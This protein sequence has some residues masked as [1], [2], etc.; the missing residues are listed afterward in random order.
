MCHSRGTPLACLALAAAVLGLG[1]GSGCGS[2]PKKDDVPVAV[3][4]AGPVGPPP[5]GEVAGGGLTGRPV[6]VGEM[7]PTAAAGRP[8]VRPM[9]VR[10]ESWTDKPAALTSPV[11]RREA[12]QFSVLGWDGPRA[13]LFAVAGSAETDHGV[14]AI[15]AYAGHSPCEKRRGAA[16]GVMEPEC[17]AALRGCGLAAAVLEPAGGFHARPAEEDPD[18][19]AFETGGACVAAGKLIVDIDR[20]GKPEAYPVAGFASASGAPSEE[21]A[22]V[23]GGGATC[24]PRF[25]FRGAVA[26]SAAGM[27]VLGV[28]DLDGDGRQEIVTLLRASGRQ[29]WVLY[30]ARESVARLERVAVATPWPAGSQP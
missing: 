7:C 6:L 25:A 1:L 15:G 20:D 9:F 23:A 2:R 24:A 29:V 28:I 12:R 26:T 8:A 5:P 4:P 10:R 14:A 3:G 18:P 16:A 21:V 22:S 19:A 11:E 17:E 30:S 13:G 27:D